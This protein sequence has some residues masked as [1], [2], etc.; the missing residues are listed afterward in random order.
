VTAEAF[1]LPAPVHGDGGLAG[2]T[3]IVTGGASGIGL[4]ISRMLAAQ[5]ASVAILGRDAGA[6]AAAVD[7]VAELGSTGMFVPVDLAD[8]DAIGPAVESV[9]ERLGAI[10]ILVNN[11]GV[12]GLDAPLGRSGLF[13]IDLENWEFVQAVNVRAPF[14]LTQAVGRH[15]IDRGEGGRIVNVTSSAAFMAANCSIHYAASKAALTS[16][17]RTSAADLG[18]HGINVNAVAPALTRTEYRLRMGGDEVLQRS[19]SQGRMENLL[20]SVADPDDVAAVV[21]F[22]CLPAS[23]QI[24]GQTI[25]TSAGLIV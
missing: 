19:V 8:T 9:L 6:G 3:A 25:H 11:A 13:E 15:M 17:T 14:L 2:R 7:L 21:L 24:T 12:R 5:G 1:D 20:H 10:D 4:A 22:L 23:R 18:P 16:L